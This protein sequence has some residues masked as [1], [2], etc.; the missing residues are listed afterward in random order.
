MRCNKCG[1][2]NPENANFCGGCGYNFASERAMY[3]QTQTE[4]FVE[5]PVDFQPEEKETKALAIIGLVL[6]IIG[7]LTAIFPISGWVFGGIGVI[8][9]IFSWS[10]KRSQKPLSITGFFVSLI[11][12]IIATVMFVAAVTAHR[13]PWDVFTETHNADSHHVNQG[14]SGDGES[15]GDTV[16]P[17]AYVEVSNRSGSFSLPSSWGLDSVN[18]DAG[19]GIFLYAPKSV[20]S[21]EASDYVCMIDM[22]TDYTYADKDTIIKNRKKGICDSIDNIIDESDIQVFISDDS[23]YETPVIVYNYSFYDSGVKGDIDVWEYDLVY[24]YQMI[25]LICYDVEDL[26]YDG[27][28]PQD[29]GKTIIETFKLN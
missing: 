5:N 13:N 10:S 14:Y 2:E 1:Y 16:S 20:A 9:C 18:S 3:T 19:S 15:D 7:L 27:D 4:S 12:I 28:K 26:E 21:D 25:A 22:D 23:V 6:G 8:L 29:I 11:A 17:N 24:D